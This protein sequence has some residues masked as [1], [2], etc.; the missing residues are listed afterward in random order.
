MLSLDAAYC[1]Y[2]RVAGHAHRPKPW[3][4]PDRILTDYLMIYVAEGSE[5]VSV[6]DE[7]HDLS[8]GDMYLLP[9]N[10]ITNKGC[11]DWSH[12][13]WVH[14]DL[15]YNKHRDEAPIA[16]CN[17]LK[18]DKAQ[19]AFLQPGPQEIYGQELPLLIPDS[20][21]TRM[22]QY[23]VEISDLFKSSVQ[24]DR[25]R[26]N[27]LI[28]EAMLL[29]VDAAAQQ[30]QRDAQDKI[31]DAERI[32]LASLDA[33][34]GVAEFAQVAGFSPSRFHDVYKQLRGITPLRFLTD[35]RM[36]SA[37]DLLKNSQLSITT[38]AAMVGHPD[39]TVFGRIFKREHGQSP[40]EWRASQV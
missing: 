35:A 26:A 30:P 39:P 36:A 11:H 13:Y 37:R 33:D 9:P 20:I 17:Q 16:P 6:G 19:N 21:K 12:P 34:F 3:S 15:I 27:H 18:F 2:I 10:K 25:V 5:W 32:A 28:S 23:V 40:R 1:P 24:I 29:F 22:A 7:Y 14:F 38:I 31:T 8:P 4:F